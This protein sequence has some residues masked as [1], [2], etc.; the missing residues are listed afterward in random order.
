MAKR[1]YIQR[2]LLIAR[3]LKAKPSTYDE[4]K[5]FLIQEQE[6]T[7]DNF[8]ISKR[9]LQRDFK[10]INS[11]YGI[12][13]TYNKK[14]RWYEISEEVE[15][16]P[17]ERILEAF[18]TLSALNFSNQVSSKLILEKRG[19]KG[20]EHINGLLYAINNNFEINI[21]HHSF[22]KRA[23]EVRTLHPIAVKE[24]QNRWYL[25]AFDTVKKDYRNFGL[26]RITKLDIT[27]KKFKSITFD[28]E[29]NYQHA[30][31]VETY[32]PATKIVLTV[33]LF[34]SK[35][36]KS[37]PLHG[38]QKVIFEDDKVCRFEYFMHPTH[39]LMMEILKYGEL[40]KVE[41]PLGFQ[42]DIRNKIK[43]MTQLYN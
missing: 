32:E 8:S 25:I 7:G 23:P 30:F 41:E 20:T 42:T 15:D 11:I 17:F 34:Q 22:W 5:D 12:E 28:T 39:D 4:I 38:S 1:D 37:L 35:Y 29:K 9:T 6:V 27:S 14:E 21:T 16:K 3:R 18:E 2:H 19:N 33:D 43:A 24:S 10:D 31:G 13:I 26:D 40:V 36:I